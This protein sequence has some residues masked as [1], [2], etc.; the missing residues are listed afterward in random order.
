MT[1]SRF[2][3]LLALLVALGAAVSFAAERSAP[4]AIGD[5]APAVPDEAITMESMRLENS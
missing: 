5:D 4:P 3:G 1:R 2:A